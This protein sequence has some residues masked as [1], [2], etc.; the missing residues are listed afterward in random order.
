MTLRVIHKLY[1]LET[2]GFYIRFRTRIYTF[3]YTDKWP[4]IIKE[5]GK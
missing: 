1:S 3:W 5:K 4:Y 2:V